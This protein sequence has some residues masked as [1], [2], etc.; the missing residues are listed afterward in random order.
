MAGY[1]HA[2]SRSDQ[3]YSGVNQLVTHNMHV[4][5]NKH[6]RAH[7]RFLFK[8][9]DPKRSSELPLSMSTTASWDCLRLFIMP[10]FAMVL[11]FT[12]GWLGLG[13]FLHLSFWTSS[14]LCSTWNILAHAL[15]CSLFP[16]K[17]KFSLRLGF[18]TSSMSCFTWSILA[19]VLG[20]GQPL[21]PDEDE[22]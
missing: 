12:M 17:D 2:Q 11:L 5:I 8:G 16:D 6:T 15:D 9:M 7:F 21:L 4:P 22:G 19:L 1:K 10:G 13:F 14:I 18:W 20:L 3:L